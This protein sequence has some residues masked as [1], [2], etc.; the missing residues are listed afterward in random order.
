MLHAGHLSELIIGSKSDFTARAAQVQLSDECMHARRTQN[1]CQAKLG[2]HRSLRLHHERLAETLCIDQPLPLRPHLRG[3]ES[4]CRALQ[5]LRCCIDA[6]MQ[7]STASRLTA[8]VNFGGV[9]P[10][11]SN[12]AAGPRPR[13]NA[14]AKAVFQLPRGPGPPEQLKKKHKTD[15]F[16]SY[17]E[18][19]EP[20]RADAPA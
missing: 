5:L 9:S 3:V 2:A 13:T 20:K 7:P 1:Q 16:P 18:A 4:W 12:S 8:L 6:G 15:K 10:R 14:A 11:E 19:G 17:K